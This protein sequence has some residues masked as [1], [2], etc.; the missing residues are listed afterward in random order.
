MPIRTPAFS[1]LIRFAIIAIPLSL[2]RV[3]PF[4]RLLPESAAWLPLVPDHPALAWCQGTR[5]ST[6]GATCCLWSLSSINQIRWIDP[7]PSRQLLTP[8]LPIP[9]CYPA[10]GQTVL[11]MRHP[12]C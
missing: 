1:Q 9:G 7:K 5:T 6:K 4:A 3:H 2:D 12:A 8:K 10:V 11:H